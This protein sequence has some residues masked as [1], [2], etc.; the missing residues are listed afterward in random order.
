VEPRKEE[1]EEEEVIELDT[2]GF[3]TKTI[4]TLA[5]LPDNAEVLSLVEKCNFLFVIYNS[6]MRKFQA[7]RDIP[8]A[9]LSKKNF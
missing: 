6:P 2:L 7:F 3:N 9:V 4:A 1:E 8:V 5:V